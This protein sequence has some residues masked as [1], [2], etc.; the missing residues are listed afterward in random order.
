MRIINS[1]SIIATFSPKKAVILIGFFCLFVFQSNGQSEQREYQKINQQIDSLADLGEYE[2]AGQYQELLELTKKKYEAL[3]AEDFRLVT[4]YIDKIN[5][6]KTGEKPKINKSKSP[7][8]EVARN[9]VTNQP[10]VKEV[11]KKKTVIYNGPQAVNFLFDWS[12]ISGVTKKGQFYAFYIDEEFKGYFLFR[13]AGDNRKY[14][15]WLIETYTNVGIHNVKLYRTQGAKKTLT[16]SQTINVTK[17][18]EFKI[19]Y[20]NTIAFNPAPT[21]TRSLSRI[22]S[23]DVNLNPPYTRTTSIINNKYPVSHYLLGSTTFIY[24][25]QAMGRASLKS[26]IVS[27]LGYQMAGGITTT[28]GSLLA[29]LPILYTYQTDYIDFNTGVVGYLGFASNDFW[30]FE[31]FITTYGFSWQSQVSFYSKANS[32]SGFSIFADVY[33]MSLSF[34][35]GIGFT[36]R[37]VS[38]K[39]TKDFILNYAG[40]PD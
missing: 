37:F 4:Q 33:P 6:V 3:K 36:S 26:P 39:H 24:E 13:G 8:F 9:Q 1:R 28:Y 25:Y 7:A 40:Q 15:I 32:A 16:M 21:N 35:L 20:A 34:S 12:T 27:G 38:Y 17:P 2:K 29:S 11:P 31:D 23:E 14:S 19:S 30:A 5:A 10:Q 22:K 18:G